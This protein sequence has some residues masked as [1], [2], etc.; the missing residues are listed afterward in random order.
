M[1]LAKMDRFYGRRGFDSDLA[2]PDFILQKLEE[3]HLSHVKP[4]YLIEKNCP[5]QNNVLNKLIFQ[6]ICIQYV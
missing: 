6:N 5:I 1:L 3:W 4:V 2:T